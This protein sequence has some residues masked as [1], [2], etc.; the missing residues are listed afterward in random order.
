M[1]QFLPPG[2]IADAHSMSVGGYCI[3]FDIAFEGLAVVSHHVR[4]PSSSLSR[5]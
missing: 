2:F 5:C 1:H 4:Q 3:M